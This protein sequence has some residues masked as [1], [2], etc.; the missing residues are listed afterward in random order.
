MRVDFLRGALP[1]D[2]RLRP[3]EFLSQLVVSI[4]SP[5]SFPLAQFLSFA[6]ASKSRHK[7]PE[8]SVHAQRLQQTRLDYVLSP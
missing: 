5:L 1:N 8:K 3:V 7:L 4:T 2:R 6:N